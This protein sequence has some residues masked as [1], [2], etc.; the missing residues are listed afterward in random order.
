M[1]GR[2]I[3]YRQS[4]PDKSNQV[5]ANHGFVMVETTFGRLGRGPIITPETGVDEGCVGFTIQFRT[6]LAHRFE[7][8]EIFQEQDPAV[9]IIRQDYQA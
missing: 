3:D 8:L 7:V 4:G 1:P 9:K 2:Y 5:V 6:V